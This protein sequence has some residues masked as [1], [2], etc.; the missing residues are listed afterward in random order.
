M[1]SLNDKQIQIIIFPKGQI[2]HSIEFGLFLHFHYINRN[3]Y[4]MNPFH[5]FRS[6]TTKRLNLVEIQQAHL[7][8]LYI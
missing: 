2:R 6:L 8:D 5:H 7:N 1:N 3:S 4:I